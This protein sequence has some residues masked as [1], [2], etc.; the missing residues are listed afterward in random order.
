MVMNRREVI[1][2]L[3][4][5]RACRRQSALPSVG[6]N[7]A[8]NT[9]EAELPDAAKFPCPSAN[10]PCPCAKIPC[11]MRKNSLLCDRR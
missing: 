11:A 4:V 1:L 8:D 5:P 2:G 10:F 9:N 7:I 6:S 3:A